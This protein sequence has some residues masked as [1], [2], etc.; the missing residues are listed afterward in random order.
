MNKF[1][2]LF[3]FIVFFLKGLSYID[4]D[5]GW[6]LRTGEYIKA[7]GIAQKDPF[8]YSMP[9][10]RVIDHE[11]F[12][13]VWTVTVYPFLGRPGLA[14][15]AAA[16]G[17]ISLILQSPR[18]EKW[19][20][21]LL[22]LSGGAFLPIIGV[23]P[24]VIS[25]LF[26]SILLIIINYK[27]NWR[28]WRV[29]IPVLFLIWANMHGSFPLGI[30]MLALYVF[31]NCWEE[32]KLL[33]IDICIVLASIALTF[34]NP[35]GSL[36]WGEVAITLSQ[37]EVHFIFAE[38]YPIFLYPY[39]PFWLLII[40]SSILIFRYRRRY[41]M[42]EKTLF[43]FLLA[44][45]MQGVRNMPYWVIFSLSLMGRGIA[46]LGSEAGK[47]GRQRLLKGLRFLSIFAGTVIV[48]QNI[49]MINPVYPE[50]AV[51][52]LRKN[53]PKGN[54]FS[55]FGWGGYMVWQLPEKKVFIDGRMSNWRQSAIKGESSN[56]LAE[57]YRVANQAE[58]IANITSKYNIDTLLL[59]PVPF[60]EWKEQYINL[61]GIDERRK[62]P[63]IATQLKEG[64]WRLVY[65]DPVAVIYQKK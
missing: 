55:D 7:H 10:Y 49:F 61:F 26:F 35:Y 16:F 40:L 3:L 57:Y 8:S 1:V 15:I 24:L 42:A 51:L 53:M 31:F 34:V 4:P 9:S 25:W 32:K 13:D 56:V 64:G 54:I 5:F 47:E 63:E 33:W 65:K 30:I 50:K 17:A 28:K 45:G 18:K 29:I 22:I 52:Y 2:Y 60:E 58:S 39:F 43:I 23:R 19:L 44:V 6:H 38:W 21:T 41:S 14:L 59:T 37:P 12:A 27:R 20:S 11:W 48:L 46:L 36:L 62:Y